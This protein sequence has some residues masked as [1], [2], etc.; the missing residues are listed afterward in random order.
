MII[1]IFLVELIFVDDM[2]LK[3]LDCYVKNKCVY[4]L[5]MK[6]CMI[7]VLLINI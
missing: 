5:E 4:L 7:V 3:N 1:I 2:L 6:F